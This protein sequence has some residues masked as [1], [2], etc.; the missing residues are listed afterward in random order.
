[1]SFD[2]MVISG[3]PQG[4]TSG[5]IL[6]T[7]FVNDFGDFM[8]HEITQLTCYADDANIS[9]KASIYEAVS[10]LIV[11]IIINDKTIAIWFTSGG[12]RLTVNE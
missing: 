12:R 4:C 9:D 10:L 8:S 7:I 6:F 3:I 1:M 5:P 11:D 2:C